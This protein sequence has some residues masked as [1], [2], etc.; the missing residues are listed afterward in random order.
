MYNIK[1]EGL[2]FYLI[3]YG[4]REVATDFVSVKS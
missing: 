3:L 4:F 2:Y 1:E